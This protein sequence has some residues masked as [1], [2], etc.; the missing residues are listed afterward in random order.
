MPLYEYVC[1]ECDHPFEALVF[2]A[3]GRYDLSEMRER[4]SRE[5]VER[6]RPAADGGGGAADGVQLQRAAV[7]PGLPAVR[8]GLTLRANSP[9]FPHGVLSGK[10]S[11]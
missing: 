1:R 4:E 10:G 5:A 3:C 2:G 11:P 6:A 8:R 7:R 9:A